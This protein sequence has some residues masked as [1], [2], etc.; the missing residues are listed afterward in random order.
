MSLLLDTGIVY[1]GFSLG[2]LAAHRLAQI[3]SGGRGGLLYHHGDVPMAMFGDT[4]PAGVD[5]QIHLSEDD[6]FREEGVAEAFVAEVGK[7]AHAE[8][9]LYPGSNHLFMDS[10]L[11]SYNEASAELAMER[12]LAFLERLR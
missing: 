3:R 12:T 2:A 6:E 9:F 7:A 10:S 8:L 5:L 1:A 11:D 4:W